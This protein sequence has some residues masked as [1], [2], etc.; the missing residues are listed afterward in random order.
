MK[1]F[2]LK[3]SIPALVTPFHDDFTINFDKLGEL[4]EFHIDNASDAILVLGTTGES[5]TISFEEQIE[6]VKY[7]IE[8][9][10]GRIHVMVGS[11][12]NDTAKSIKISQTFEKL[13]ADSLLLITP[14]YNRT[15]DS[16]M[17]KHFEAIADSVSTPVI[18]YTVPARTGCHIAP[19]VI[20]HLAK[21]PNIVGHKDATGDFS[22]SMK[23]SRYVSDE[24]ALYSGN[25]DTII[26]LLSI[27]AS[28]VISV[29]A[30]YA[31]KTVSTLVGAYAEGR[32]SEALAMQ[33]ENLDF[34]NAL[35]IETSPIPIRYAMNKAGFG[36][37][38]ARLPLDELSDGG[39]AILDPLLG[40][41]E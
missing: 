15:N 1:N 25:D 26:P 3:G 28:G 4:I 37:G 22:Y 9:A 32:H 31:P 18:L 20:A 23:I 2:T 19:H 40:A 30:N 8:K 21:H 29:W 36:I 34:I 27:G 16:G 10:A 5:P 24:F 39:K 14:Y 33:Q 38:P 6:I 35:F 12:S 17:I 13:G 41:G 7:T 11:G